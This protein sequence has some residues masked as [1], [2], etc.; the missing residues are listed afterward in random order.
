MFTDTPEEDIESHYRWFWVTMWLLGIELRTSGRAV[1]ALSYWAISPAHNSPFKDSLCCHTLSPHARAHYWVVPSWKDYL[2]D[3]GRTYSPRSHLLGCSFWVLGWVAASVR[4]WPSEVGQAFVGFLY[5]TCIF[6]LF[7]FSLGQTQTGRGR[8]TCKGTRYQTSEG[9]WVL[10]LIR[11]SVTHCNLCWS[12]RETVG[13]QFAVSDFSEAH[14]IIVSF[15]ATWPFI[16]LFLIFNIEA[17]HDFASGLCFFNQ[18]NI[19]K[20]CFLCL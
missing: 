1:S 12:T 5:F 4:P 13:L 11:M 9:H 15:R 3:E 18:D 8:E 19:W 20:G 2:L 7:S 6:T 16:Y 14:R 10:G 17:F